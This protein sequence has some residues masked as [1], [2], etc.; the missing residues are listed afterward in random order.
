M[1]ELVPVGPSAPAPGSGPVWPPGQPLLD[2]PTMGV[3]TVGSP[4]EASQAAMM[5][6]LVDAVVA[7]IEHKVIDELER[8]GQRHGWAAF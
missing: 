1:N 5:D 2:G 3:G 6:D 4:V 7:R 8:R